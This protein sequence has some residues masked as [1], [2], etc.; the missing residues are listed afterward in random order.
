MIGGLSHLLRET[1]HAGLVDRIPLNQELQLV[2]RYIE[3]QRARFGERLTVDVA[4]EDDSVRHALVPSLLLQPFVEN[5]IKH[6]IGSRAGP[7]R[8]EIIVG[9]RGASLL[10]EVRDDGRGL[11]SGAVSEG[12]GMANCRARLL[13]LYGLAGRLEI[14]NRDRGGAT[15][16]IELPFQVAP[17]EASA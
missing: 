15:V 3:I 1:L 7:G 8:I 9:R 11:Q 4:V 10:I 13:T 2:E 17:V 12:V 6:G 16:R 5:S 14:A